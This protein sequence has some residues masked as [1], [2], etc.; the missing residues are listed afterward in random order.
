[1]WTSALSLGMFVGPVV[2]GFL[3]DQVGFRWGTLYVLVNMIIMV[4]VDLFKVCLI[5]D[6]FGYELFFVLRWPRF[7]HFYLLK[8][9]PL[10][11]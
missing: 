2:G 9:L 1:M 5:Y 8:A 11:S 4:G 10:E 7:L 3:L 6:T